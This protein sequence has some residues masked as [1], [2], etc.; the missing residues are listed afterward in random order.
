MTIKIIFNSIPLGCS[1][2]N[3]QVRVLSYVINRF[4]WFDFSQSFERL[5]GSEKN[6]HLIFMRD[7]VVK[8]SSCYL[9]NKQFNR[10]MSGIYFKAVAEQGVV[11]PGS[12]YI[13]APLLV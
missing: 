4:L 10:Q 2:P 5:V 8:S 13:W 1:L 11:P 7:C 12:K 6:K 3:G 9:R